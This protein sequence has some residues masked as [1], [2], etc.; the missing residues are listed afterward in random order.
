MSSVFDYN[1]DEIFKGLDDEAEHESVGGKLE[2]IEKFS[3]ER[4]VTGH[5]PPA[6]IWHTAPD[7]GVPV[8]NSLL[9]AGALSKHKIPFE[10]HVYPYGG[11]GLSTVDTHTCDHLDE[12]TAHAHDWMDA[13]KKWLK[14]VL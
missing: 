1:F 6:F 10:L 8:M 13:V 9:Y 4:H 11:H 7:D 3:C 14:L 5:T 2:D 12:K